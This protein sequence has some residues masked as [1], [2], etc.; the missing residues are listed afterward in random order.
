MVSRAYNGFPATY[1]D[2][3]GGR[4][5]REFRSGKQ[6]RPDTCRLCGLKDYE[7]TVQAHNEDYHEPDTF[8]G[9]CFYCH[10][11]VHKRFDSLKRWQKWRELVSSGWQPPRNRDYRIFIKVWDDI[12]AV[13]NQNPQT[14]D[15]SNWAW[16]LTD[17]EPDLYSPRAAELGLP[18]L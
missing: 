7:A 15:Y 5:Y 3:Q 17:Y 4:V 13:S 11:A 12:L 2:K 9:I 18:P 6:I 1:R 16:T 14:T 10:M 8:I